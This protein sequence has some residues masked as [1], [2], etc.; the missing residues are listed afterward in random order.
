MEPKAAVAETDLVNELRLDAGRDSAKMSGEKT[1]VSGK[2]CVRPEYSPEVPESGGT[3][4]CR[5]DI[6]SSAASL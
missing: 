6:T 1:G 3:C 4:S 5:G 2:V